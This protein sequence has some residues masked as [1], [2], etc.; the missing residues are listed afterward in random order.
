MLEEELKDEYFA[1]AVGFGS[2]RVGLLVDNLLE[3][4]EIVIKPLGEHLKDIQG[5]AG[6]AEIGKHKIVLVLDVD[7]MMEESFSRKNI[8]GS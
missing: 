5:L 3:Q 1:I 6:A 7:S 2:K 4:T 8:N